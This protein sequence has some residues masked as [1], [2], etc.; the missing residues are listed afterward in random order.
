MSNLET[1]ELVKFL[2]S[3]S[4][5]SEVS[6][7]SLSNFCKDLNFESYRKNETIFEKGDVGKPCM[8]FLM[9]K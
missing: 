3:V 2:S 4:F 1:N 6:E 8:L 5:F 9:E 7:T